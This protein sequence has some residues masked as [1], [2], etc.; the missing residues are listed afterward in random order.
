MQLIVAVNRRGTGGQ[1]PMIIS[2]GISVLAGGS[3]IA[4]ASAD[5]PVLT[6][7]IGCAVPGAIFFLTP[8]IRLG[9]AAKAD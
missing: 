5:D 7:A 6:N 2:G 1:W 4:G 9:R 3:C 8:A